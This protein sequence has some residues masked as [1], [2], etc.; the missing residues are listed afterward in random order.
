[1]AMAVANRYARALADVVSRTGD[2]RSV[3]GE[4]EDFAVAYRQSAELREVLTTPAVPL[5]QK[6][7]VLEAILARLGMSPVVA[8][9]LRVLA[10]NY[11]LGLL[12]QVLRAFRKIAYD[13]LGIVRVEVTS[14]AELSQTEREELLELFGALT[15]KQV[16]GQF[17]IEKDLLG[18]VLAQIGSTVYDGSVRGHLQ[19]IRARLRAR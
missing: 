15:R 18:G 19:R 2:Y 4:L 9:F 17:R 12:D 11:R 7:A 16:E 5:P 3:L 8:N 14:A 13:R 10:D 1:M 6:H